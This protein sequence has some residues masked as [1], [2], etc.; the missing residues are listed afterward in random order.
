MQDARALQSWSD[1]NLIVCMASD[2][3]SNN[4]IVLE[5]NNCITA[6]RSHVCDGFVP[7]RDL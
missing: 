7:A 3:N 5:D 1:T 4:P 2:L 6:V